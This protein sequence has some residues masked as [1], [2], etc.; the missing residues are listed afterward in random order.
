MAL[1]YNC[2]GQMSLKTS[3]FKV[4]IKIIKNIE[5]I[6]MFKNELKSWEIKYDYPRLS[7]RELHTNFLGRAINF[8]GFIMLENV[9]EN[10]N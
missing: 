4:L 8:T 6:S 1:G 5:T 2:R 3:I 9:T 7:N 10:R